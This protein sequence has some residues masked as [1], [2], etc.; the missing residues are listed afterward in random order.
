[1]LSASYLLRSIRYLS[2]LG[3]SVKPQ[4]PKSKSV[5]PKPAKNKSLVEKQVK[6]LTVK[7]LYASCESKDLNFTS[8][9]S[10]EPINEFVGQSRAQEAIRFA[11]AMP[12]SGY[13]VYAVGRNGLGKR[14]MIMRYLDHHRKQIPNLYDWCYVADFELPRSPKVLKLPVGMGPSLKADIEKLM[15]RLVKAI[16]QTFENDQYY[17]RSESLKNEYADK[18]DNALEKVAKQARR[19]KIKL[20]LSTPGGYR[21]TA[22]NGEDVHTVESFEALSEEQKSQFEADINK[23][24]LKLRGVIRKI[25]VWE[26]EFLDKQQALNEE[27]VL[28][29]TQHLIESLAQKYHQY[30]SVIQYLGDLQKDIVTNIDGFLED[31]DDQGALSNATLE[32]KL[33]RRYQVNVLVHH[34]DDMAPIVVEENPNYHTLFGYVEHVTYKGTVFTDYSLIRSGCVHR[35]NGGYLLLDAV[36]VLEQPFVWDGIKRALRSKEIQINSLEREVTLSGTIS[37]EPEAIPLDI[38][39]ILF[40]DRETY[41]LLQNYDPEFEELFKVTADFE[42]EMPRTIESQ[43]KYAKF[44]SS[45]TH[46]K[47]FLHCDKKAVSRIIE[48]S[49]RQAE[50]QKKLSLQA[51]EISNLLR[52]SNFWAKEQSSTMIRQSHIERA[53]ESQE[54]RHGR[55]KDQVFDTIRDGTTLLTVTGKVI[56]QINALSV[57]YSAGSEFGMP[58]RVTA[59]CYFGDG[60][61]ID[62]EHHS[63]LGGN[64][65]T[66]GVLILSSYLSSLFAKEQ[67]MPLSASIAF[68]QSYGEVDGDSASLAEFCA[69]ISSLAEVPILQNFAVTGSVNQFGEVQPVGGVNEKIEG[70]FDACELIGLDGKQGVLLPKSNVVN[71][72]LNQR[73]LNSV[74]KGKFHI[75]PVEHVSEALELLTEMPSGLNVKLAKIEKKE[76]TIFDEIQKKLTVLRAKNE[77]DN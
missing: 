12:D 32:K 10:L 11:M 13:N 25:A 9:K 36:K 57:Y 3:C 68:E 55:L 31:N 65:H 47:G 6:S 7:E 24:E 69:L 72:M 46:E 64:I 73:V 51:A 58:N 23:L 40:G 56:G 52:E 39:I 33:P 50:H 8:T 66:K 37:L 75:Y 53:L 44:I 42:N 63:K 18:Q 70:F 62:I 59:N 28:G 54:H 76:H 2:A 49:S 38:K 35:A 74:K 1:M 27:V 19:K 29:V 61:I 30:D 45:L 21:L 67:M 41:M 77:D 16:P 15:L 43:N 22:M 4:S 14:T 5:K 48:Y 26:Q 20:S 17:E 71:L 34:T 60:D